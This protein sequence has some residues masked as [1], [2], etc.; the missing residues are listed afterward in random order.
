MK[1]LFLLISVLLSVDL[2]GQ[3]YEMMRV[4]KIDVVLEG[5]TTSTYFDVKAL[6][7][8]MHTK[9]GNFFSQIEFDNDLKMLA[10]EYE[11]VDSTMTVSGNQLCITLHIWL[12][13]AIREI[14]F[15]GNQRVKT[16]K[17]LKELELEKG[18]PYERE[19]FIKAFNK[20]K[21]LYIKKG[22]FESELDFETV[23]VEGCNEVDIYIHVDEG[24]AGKINQIE[25]CGL[26]KCDED[27]ILDLMVTKKY[28]F[29][30]SWYLGNGCYN[31]EMIEH[32]R[33]QIINFFQNQGYADAVVNICLEESKKEN[34]ISVVISV[35]KGDKYWIGNMGMSG[36]CVF[37]NQQIWSKFNFGRDSSYSPEKIRQ[38]IKA[39]NEL[40]GAC[41]YIDASVDVQL[42]LRDNEN[43]YD[44]LLL[45]D[46]GEQYHVGM[47]KVF[48]N[49]CT[50][51]SLI[52]HESILCPGEVFNTKKLKGTETRLTNT[53]YFESVN[54]YAVKSQ[55]EDPC[56]EQL[57]RDVYIEVQETDTGNVGLFFGFSSLE[58]L[59][60]G[61][62]VSEQNFNIGGLT[63]VLEKGPG[64]LRGAGEYAHFKVNVGDRQTSYLAQ[65]TKP[66]F[67][68]TPWIIGV[69]LEKNDNRVL[70]RAYEVKTWGGSVHATYICNEYLKYN[71]YYRAIRTRTSVGSDPTQLLETEGDR[72]GFISA[73]GLNFLYDSTDH[74]RKPTDGFRSRFLYEIAGL[75]G[76]YQF[77]KFSYLNSYYYPI[78]KKGV[79][80]FR[81]ELQFIHTYGDTQ[82]QDLPLSERL[83]LGGET[84]VRGYKPFV[85]GPLFGNREPRGG[86]SSLLFTEEYQHNLLKY[87][88]LDLFGFV[89]GGMVSLSE[90][91][92]SKYAASVGL[93]VRFE[94]MR[95]VPLMMG[96]GWPI[97]PIV[98]VG[99]VDVDNSQRFFFSMGGN[100]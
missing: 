55:F 9:A 5:Q 17:L 95:N 39:V 12:K 99:G 47:I 8:R 11:R 29:L 26:T 60:G 69:D 28:N 85:I 83:F 67:L 56:G 45:I 70:S 61:V 4:G 43:V 41:G 58:Q 27:D 87:P 66:Y 15:S 94:V 80:K 42:S 32:D 10:D 90:F 72:S 24:R 18:S 22:Y 25:F 16:K 14:C 62:E 64:A 88:C 3:N 23:P 82:E 74:P 78:T 38:T 91:T 51:T 79:L 75:G 93:G 81:A 53:G 35:D 19:E 34:R 21:R 40:Y 44:L 96:Y 92:I 48:G 71:L 57:Y 33:L 49:Q 100:F 77:M 52:L 50:K 54:V 97:H 65:W 6:R 20:L 36:N 7:A 30:L 63:R 13:P 86:V 73:T 59:F 31:P 98:K 37:T 2:F 68:D 76:N 46:E 89:D 1:R 84:T